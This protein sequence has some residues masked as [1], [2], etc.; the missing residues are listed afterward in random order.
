MNEFEWNKRKA[1]LNLTDH[2]VSFEEASTVFDDERYLIFDDPVHS[3]EEN[4]YIAIGMSDQSRLLFV[5]YTERE[6]KI[7][8]IS[9]RE[10]TRRERK[11]YE[12]EDI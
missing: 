12:Q 10:V 7:R 2:G 8:L 1:E 11:Q 6:S 9:A 5:S 4:R 3:W